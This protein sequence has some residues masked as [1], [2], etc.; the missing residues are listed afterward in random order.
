METVISTR[1]EQHLLENNLHDP[2]QSAY[3]K[4]HSTET[5]LIKI[6]HDIVLALDSGRVAALVLLDLSAAFRHD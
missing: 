4:Q 5:A 1:I 6:Q 3:R 2:L